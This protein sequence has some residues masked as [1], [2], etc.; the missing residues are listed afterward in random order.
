M[1][2]K[3]SEKKWRSFVRKKL[4]KI[5]DKPVGY[6]GSN[7]GL[8]NKPA[9]IKSSQLYQKFNSI[10]EECGDITLPMGYFIDYFNFEENDYFKKYLQKYCK[11]RGI[12]I[13]FNFKDRSV[14]IRRK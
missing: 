9:R 6:I 4:E 2:K 5:T 11:E 14:T 7:F 13:R 10:V 3:Y 8:F 1:K 12:V